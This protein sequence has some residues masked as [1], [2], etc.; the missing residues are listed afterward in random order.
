MITTDSEVVKSHRMGFF[1]YD[2]AS[3]TRIEDLDIRLK[4]NVFPMQDQPS[5]VLLLS[6]IIDR[7]YSGL[8]VFFNGG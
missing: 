4:R 8:R 2:G 5:M 1:I 6:K 7:T 3:A